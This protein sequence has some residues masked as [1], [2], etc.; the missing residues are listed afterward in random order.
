MYGLD[1][2]LLWQFLGW[3]IMGYGG[4]IHYHKERSGHRKTRDLDEYHLASSLQT[5]TLSSL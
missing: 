2:L 3:E 1:A 5:H 4:G